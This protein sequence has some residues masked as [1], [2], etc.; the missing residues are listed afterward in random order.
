MPRPR[1]VDRPQKKTL[2]LPTSVC[3]E[4]DSILRDP[5]TKKPEF[6]AWSQLVEALLRKWLNGEL[7]LAAFPIPKVNLDSLND[8]N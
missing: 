3:D 7:Q 4:V 5:L 6:S 2:S 8:P 1:H